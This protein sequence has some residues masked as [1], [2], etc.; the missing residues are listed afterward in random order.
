MA[1]RSDVVVVTINYRCVS[2]FNLDIKLLMILY[3]SLGTLGFL[4]LDDGVMNGNFGIADQITALQWVK[5]HI[6]NFGGDPSLV[7]IYV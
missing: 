1:S 7:T 3:S 6:A 2:P 5:K 4:A